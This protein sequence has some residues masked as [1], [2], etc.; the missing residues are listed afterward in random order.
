MSNG[1]A[2]PLRECVILGATGLTK[3]VFREYQLNTNL[4]THTREYDFGI[5]DSSCREPNSG[6]ATRE[7]V[8][9]Y[10]TFPP[11]PISLGNQF[12]RDR[13]ESVKVYGRGSLISETDYLYDEY[14]AY[15][16][17]P[18]T[19]APFAHDAENF[20]STSTAPRGNA[21]TIINKCFSVLGT[22]ADSVTHFFYDETGQVVKTIDGN[23]NSPTFYSYSDVFSADSGIPQ[24][25]TNTYLTKIT[26]PTTNNVSHITQYMYGYNDGKVRS[27]TD[28]NNQIT[29][30][31]YYTGGCAGST[32]DPWLRLTETL[33]PDGGGSR[34]V[35]VDGGPSPS[36]TSSTVAAPNPTIQTNVVMDQ[37]GRTVQTQLLSD[38]AGTV[39]T[40]TVYDGFGRVYSTTNPYRS[41]SDPTYGTTT[42][43][44]D[45]MGR[46]RKQTYPDQKFVTWDY[47][48]NVTTSTDE[49][50]RITSRVTDGLGRLTTVTE[51]G[52]LL[53]SYT[54]DAL[55]NLLTVQ[56]QGRQTGLPLGASPDAPRRRT[57]TYD[58]L[59]RL[60]C[61]S[62]PENSTHDC[63]LTAATSIPS[64]VT[65]YT[66]DPNGNLSS[67]ID[68]RGVLTQYAYDAINRLIRKTFT[69]IGTS[70]EK[71][72]LRAISMTRP[73][74]V[75]RWVTL[76]DA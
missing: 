7:T 53:T 65:S 28:E 11:T 25:N 24:G 70:A 60:R 19:P 51:P 62:N 35:Y 6:S 50:T 42:F 21:T 36:V 2:S 4:P 69:T 31:C 75:Q 22:C 64:G 16:L 34:Q 38:P 72:K 1:N 20:S 26:R 14:S 33:Y 76:W 23:N 56:Q 46:P 52:G 15:P 48:G 43:A 18:V 13:P 3:G 68:S 45:S 73:H 29:R 37:V 17:V 49:M 67:K 12:I 32:L 74:P 71:T 27:A 59:S 5:L 39:L 54:Y 66:Y 55:N 57:F 47:L 10:H 41:Q 40:D 9:V 8:I 30:F 61:S 44:Y 58:S 63:P